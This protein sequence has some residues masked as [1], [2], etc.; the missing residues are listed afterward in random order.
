MSYFLASPGDSPPPRAVK[1]SIT[2]RIRIW[3]VTIEIEIEG[4]RKKRSTDD[5]IAEA[6]RRGIMANHGMIGNYQVDTSSIV[7][8]DADMREYRVNNNLE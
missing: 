4:G 3:F 5:E 7:V 8:E 1:W 6:I 2:I